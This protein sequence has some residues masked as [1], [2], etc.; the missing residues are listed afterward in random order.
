[1]REGGRA[2]GVRRPYCRTSSAVVHWRHG[3][4]LGASVTAF[5]ETH[6]EQL[7][8]D[9]EEWCESWSE[10]CGSDCIY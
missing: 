3:V 8:R 4:R 5:I 7:Y 6:H 2:V 10:Y 1:M 9:E